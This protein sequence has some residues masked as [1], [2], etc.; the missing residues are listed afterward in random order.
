MPY[1][2]PAN[3]RS[4]RRGGPRRRLA[5]APW[6]VIGLVTVLVL[7]GVTVGYLRLVRE[8][9]TGETRATIAASPSMVQLLDGLARTWSEEEPAVG[10]VCAAVDVESADSVAM[11]ELLGQA[12]DDKRGK[13]PDVW[14]P[15]S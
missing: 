6:I 7:S 3:V 11:S 9:C 2:R 1:G 12:W 5:V 10:G 13:P 15:E 8:S 4:H 14:V